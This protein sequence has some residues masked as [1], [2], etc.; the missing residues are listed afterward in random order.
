MGAVDGSLI[1]GGLGA[2]G[3]AIG[4][5]ELA[6]AGA[7]LGLGGAFSDA[8]AAGFTGVGGSVADAV[9]TGTLAADSGLSM[10]ALAQAANT[11]KGLGGL[12]QGVNG[13]MQ[14]GNMQNAA[15]QAAATANPFGPYRAQYG[16]M[17]SN[18]M[19]DP[20]DVL[21]TTPGYQ[22]GLDAV[23]RAGAAQG[24]TGS[25]NMMNSLLQYGGNIFNQ[26]ASLLGNLA[27]AGFNP[28]TGASIQM[29]GATNAAQL[30][31]QGLNS[32]TYG[33]TNLMSP[34]PDPNVNSGT[35]SQSAL[36]GIGSSLGSMFGGT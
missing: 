36:G 8:A 13:L 24:F 28:G 2:S 12:A 32:L 5:G 35:A 21:P 15:N 7:T 25:G 4:A 1:A 14:S 18:L 6:G 34:A 19:I 11:A 31:G 20:K 33:L 30:Q 9:G 23:Q 29:Q 10:S 26:Q 22:A 27:G 16:Q 17:L 3:A